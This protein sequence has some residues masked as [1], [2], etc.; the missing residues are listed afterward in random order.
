MPAMLEPLIKRGLV[1]P[2]DW[3]RIPNTAKMLPQF[4]KP[5]NSYVDGKCYSLPWC[6][7]YDAPISLPRSAEQR[8]PVR[9][10]TLG[11]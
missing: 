1:A 10:F 7:G 2:L 8:L 6:T 3:W 11:D 5:I 9:R 4:Q